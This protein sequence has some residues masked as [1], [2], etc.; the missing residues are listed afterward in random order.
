M[1]LGAAVDYERRLNEE[2][3]GNWR[4]DSIEP[5]TNDDGDISH[6]VVIV[7]RCDPHRDPN[8][9]VPNAEMPDPV[10]DVVGERP[11]LNVS[12]VYA[13]PHLYQPKQVHYVLDDGESV[14]KP[15][16]TKTNGHYEGTVK[17]LS[18]HFKTEQNGQLK[19]PTQEAIELLASRFDSPEEV[20]LA[21]PEQLADVEGINTHI[22][23]KIHH[24]YSDRVRSTVKDDS[25]ASELIL[26]EDQ[27]GVLRVPDEYEEQ[28][29]EPACPTLPLT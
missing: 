21:D 13:E 11:S 15:P 16:K 2:L 9:P 26:V 27:D 17:T 10:S 3:R 14:K 12:A 5:P 24:R 7:Y 29:V 1:K 25:N 18:S 19:D 28:D 22:A 20:I 4:A 23:D 6:F 8:D